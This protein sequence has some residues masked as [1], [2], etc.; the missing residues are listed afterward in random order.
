MKLRQLDLRT[1]ILPFVIATA[2]EFAALFFWLKY[3]DEG[4]FIFANLV[5]WAG[6]AVERAAVYLWIR[7]IYRKKEGR[8]ESQPLLVTLAGLFFITLSEILIWILWLSIAGGDISWLASS[9]TVNFTLAGVI[10]M[11]LMLVEHSVEMAALRRTKPLAYIRS[12]NT[13]LFTFMEVA[14][15]M[16]WLYFV[17]ADRPVLGA[18]CLL[19]GLSIEHVLQGSEL[20]PDEVPL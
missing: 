8:T 10:L 5:L 19:V 4:R 20:R 12:P 16:G 9:F 14:G 2:G 11:G 17:R 7:F 13:I 6:F 1:D 3:L 15:A 18:V